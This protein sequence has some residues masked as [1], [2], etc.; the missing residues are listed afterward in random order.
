MRG[1][2]FVERAGRT[3]DTATKNHILL[4]YAIHFCANIICYV[5]SY[6]T[7]YTHLLNMPAHSNGEHITPSQIHI[8][9]LPYELCISTGG[10][11]EQ[12]KRNQPA[13]IHIKLNFECKG[14]RRPCC[15]AQ[16]IEVNEQETNSKRTDL[17]RDRKNH[18]HR[19]PYIRDGRQ[20][21]CK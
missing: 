15:G 1:M 5:R 18:T 17:T 2:F 16:R 14:E 20:E 3:E 13:L 19:A 8:T 7:W 12:A 9:H 10:I 21:V 6:L 4:Q 11:V